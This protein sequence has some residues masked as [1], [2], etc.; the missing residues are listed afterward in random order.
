MTLCVC[1]WV[2][3]QKQ[4]P[5]SSTGNE[6]D[7]LRQPII[8]SSTNSRYSA[9]PRAQNYRA[10]CEASGGAISLNRLCVHAKYLYHSTQ[11]NSVKYSFI[12]YIIGK[13]IHQCNNFVP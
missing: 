1:G 7:S 11:I 8:S 12:L 3:T 9:K 5:S 2:N 4:P 6:L 10:K 13:I